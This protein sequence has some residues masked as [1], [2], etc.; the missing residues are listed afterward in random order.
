MSV[1]GRY[2]GSTERM[3]TR[4]YSR[5]TLHDV[6]YKLHTCMRARTYARTHARVHAYLY[7]NTRAHVNTYTH[8]Q[9]H[10]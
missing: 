3:L 4:T 8:S 10:T 9:V 2:P 1:C 7:T 5:I 6:Y